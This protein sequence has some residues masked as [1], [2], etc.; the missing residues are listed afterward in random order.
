MGRGL[1]E[2]Q[3]QI[4]TVVYERRQERDFAQEEREWHE[5]VANNPYMQGASYWVYYDMRH[6]EIIAKLYDWPRYWSYTEQRYIRPSEGARVY[7]WS[8]NWRRDWIGF[9]EYNR[10]TASYYRAVSRLKRRALLADR[11]AGLWITDEGIRAV[12][13]LMVR[14]S[15]AR[16]NFA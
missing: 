9:E 8:H 5:S 1:S 12:E 7:D 10:K 6:P 2:L 3:K 11:G 4:L 14:Q 16:T 15:P 13:D